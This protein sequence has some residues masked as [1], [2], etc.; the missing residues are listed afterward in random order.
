MLGEGHV[1]S[2]SGEQS[3]MAGRAEGSD[4]KGKLQDREE[5]KRDGDDCGL[6]EVT[7]ALFPD[8][9]GTIV[10]GSGLLPTM[11]ALSPH[12]SRRWPGPTRE[13]PRFSQGCGW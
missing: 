10:C 11:K 12:Q 1:Q 5:E 9:A 13:L 3:A 4:G 2:V 7:V 8:E 6:G